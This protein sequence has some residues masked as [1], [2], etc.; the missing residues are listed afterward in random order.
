[1]KPLDVRAQPNPERFSE[2][3]RMIEGTPRYNLLDL[4]FLREVAKTW[5]AAPD[6]TKRMKYVADTMHTSPKNAQKWVRA[7]DDAGLISRKR[8]R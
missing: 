5:K 7:A 1:M 8:K 2:A 6:K 3:R 4:D